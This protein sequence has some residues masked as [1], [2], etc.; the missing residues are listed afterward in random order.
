MYNKYRFF[1]CCVINI[2]RFFYQFIPD[3]PYF[4]IG[5]NDIEA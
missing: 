4:H 3:P 2:G 5:S 1:Y